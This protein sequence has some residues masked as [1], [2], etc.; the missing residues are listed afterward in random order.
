METPESAEL[1]VEKRPGCFLRIGSIGI[2]QLR[3]KRVI[4][5][6]EFSGGP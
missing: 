6:V 5:R 1:S 3:G 4:N 2:K